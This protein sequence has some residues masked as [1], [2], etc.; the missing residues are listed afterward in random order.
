MITADYVAIGVAVISLFA[1]GVMGFGKCLKMITNGIVGTI[2]SIVLCYFLFGVVLNLEFVKNLLDKLNTALVENGSAICMFL[3][4]IK[5]DMIIVGVVLFI[6]VQILRKL[7]FSLICDFMESDFIVL[8]ILNKI[9]GVVLFTALVAVI[10]LVVFQISAWVSGSESAI[11]GF[12]QGSTFK[13]DEFYLNNP[14]NSI[15]ERIRQTVSEALA[16][17]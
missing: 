12:V 1:G 13:L 14:L 17:S 11:Y 16:I 15:F 6:V 3:L 10:V 2:M 9:G 4:K 7:V 8:K 5:I